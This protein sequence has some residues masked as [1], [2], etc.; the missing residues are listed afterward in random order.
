MSS[1]RGIRSSAGVPMKIDNRKVGVLFVNYRTP[2]HFDNSEVN[3]LQIF[4]NE[5]A[6]AIN[7]T[8]L[9]GQLQKRSA[10]LEAVYEASKIVTASVERK[11]ILDSI[12]E[13]VVEKVVPVHEKKT[14]AGSLQV[15]DAQYQELVL[16]SVYPPPSTI[17]WSRRSSKR[18]SIVPQPGQKLGITARAASKM[19]PQNVPDVSKD[20]DYIPYSAAARSELAFPLVDGK[21]LL[22]VLDIECEQENA[23][24]ETDIDAIKAL[25]ELS[26]VAL[27]NA[28]AAQEMVRISSIASMGAWGA[29]LTHEMKSELANIRRK[30]NIIEDEL[31]DL[32]PDEPLRQ[33]IEECD[34][35]DR[36]VH[37]Q[38]QVSSHAKKQPGGGAVPPRRPGLRG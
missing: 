26:V 35:G 12:L 38:A 33:R 10:H 9:Y 14:I 30:T 5:A 15:Y 2:H 20:Q 7:D 36:A 18:M 19:E 3:A 37:G 24:D 22:G 34:P 4:A 6:V 21:K 13:Q 31:E 23:F 28:E 29:E 27:R 11:K 32:P 17:R 16:E 1:G 8:K 25:A